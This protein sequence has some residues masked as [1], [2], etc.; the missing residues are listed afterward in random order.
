MPDIVLSNFLQSSA[1]ANIIRPSGEFYDYIIT[2]TGCAGL[3]LAM[4]II[5]TGRLSDKKILLV[6]AEEKNKNDRTWCF[7]EESDGLFQ[8]IVFKEWKQLKFKSVAFEKDLA[9]APYTYKLIRGIDFYQYC[10]D[11]IKSHPNIHIKQGRVEE[12]SSHKNDTYIKIDGEITRG[13][14]IFNSIIFQKPVLTNRHFWLQQHFKGWFIEADDEVFDPGSATIMDFNTDQ[15][16][17]TSFF[18]VLPFSKTRALIEYTLFS[19]QLLPDAEYDAALE[20]YITNTLSINS[21]TVHERESGS[22]PMTNYRF[23]KADN[24]IINIGTAGGQ[25]KGS[26]GY[27][28]RFIQKHSEAMAANLVKGVYPLSPSENN[29][30]LFYDSILLRILQEGTVE[31]RE[32]FR[33]LFERNKASSILKF[34]D[35]GTSLIEELPIIGSLPT[36][37]FL[38]AAIKQ[39]TTF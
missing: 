20:N 27:T 25:T 15:K 21:Y 28:F 37:P 17:G 8:P 6:D 32:I 12:I 5:A 35:N 14:F 1:K 4:H 39:T 36:F 7:W 2:G 11:Q 23:Q 18:Y 31:G 30:F 13:R 22:I 24:N 34:L 29:R 38:K 33:R 26:S 16:N 3:S 19:P 9:I 10:F